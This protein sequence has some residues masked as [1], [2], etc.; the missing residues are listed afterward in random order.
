MKLTD[1]IAKLPEADRAEAEKVIGEAVAAGNVLA[2]IDSQ[3]KAFELI[4]KTPILKSAFDAE[5]STT[6]K[7]HDDKFMS[8]KLPKLVEAKVKELTGPETDPIKLELAQIK[9]ERAAEKA[10][11]LKAKHLAIALKIAA[12]EKI[13]VDDIERFLGED[14]KSTGESVKAYAARIKAFRDAAVE[15][16]KTQRFGN[17]GK[18]NG[19]T[20]A[21]PGSR[22]ATLEAAFTREQ[23]AGNREKADRIYV[24]MMQEK[25]NNPVR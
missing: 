1:I 15:E 7:N 2:G 18:P 16:S 17:V 22:L 9:A 8:D 5:I 10:E 11:A 14:E 20:V 12:E 24:E 4:K 25:K 23:K 21:A 3:E 19:G 13:P 6:V